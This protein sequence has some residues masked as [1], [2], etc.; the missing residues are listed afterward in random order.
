MNKRT[1]VVL[2]GL[3]LVG[4]TTMDPYTREEK[5][6]SATKGA[7]IGAAAGAVVGAIAKDGKGAVVGATV[8]ALAGG[9][10]GH[11]MDRQEAE[12]RREL[13]G[14]GVSVTREGNQIRLNMPGNVTFDTDQTNIRPEFQPVLDSVV[15]V[16]NKFNET[17]L[18]VAGHTDS[19]GS[20]SYNQRLSEHRALSVKDYLALRGVAPQ[21]LTAVGYGESRPLASNSSA[22]GRAAN[23]RVELDLIP[24]PPQ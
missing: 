19:V 7:V 4:C 1:S 13:E 6:S 8:G 11:Y 10:I 5:T 14:T 15:K 18:R 17:T 21:R 16:A 2:L 9:G 23:R 22:E 20:D 24:P 3:W 12:L